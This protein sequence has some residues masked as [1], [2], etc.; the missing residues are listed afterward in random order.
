MEFRLTYRGPLHGNGSRDEKHA[1]RRALHP[2]LSQLWKQIPL[3]DYTDPANKNFL[4]PDPPSGKTTLVQSWGGFLFVPLVSRRIDVVCQLDVLF[5]RRCEPGAIIGHGGDIDNR[6]KT[7][8]DA[9]RMPRNVDELPKGC[10]PG[11]DEIPFFCLLEDDALVTEVK[12]TTDRLLEPAN[13][14]EE[15]HAFLVMKVV[16]KAIR[17]TPNNININS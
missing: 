15:A 6:L 3:K 1:I 2:Q 16:V 5:L 8:F 14:D 17:L 4:D 7:L 12:V 11:A 9:L 13:A 10:L